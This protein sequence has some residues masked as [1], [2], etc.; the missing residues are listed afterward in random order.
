MAMKMRQSLAQLEQEFRHEA[1]L[2]RSRRENLRRRAL[3]RSRKRQIAR[4]R[5]RSSIR[6]WVLMLS[7]V[8]T[9]V[10]VTIAMFETLYYLL[11]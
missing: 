8:A 10:V 9:A 11:G 3:Q 2:D 1:Q 5:V 4:E 6:F 7:L